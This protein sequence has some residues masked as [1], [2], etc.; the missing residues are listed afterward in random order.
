MGETIT[1]QQ[2]LAVGGLLTLGLLGLCG[3]FLRRLLSD[4][5][6]TKTK[7][8]ELSTRVDNL[9]LSVEQNFVSFDTFETM[10]VEFRANFTNIFQSQAKVGEILARLDE[11][12]KWEERL[13]TILD[14]VAPPR[15]GK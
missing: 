13:A 5:D 9:K 14:R 10:R 2:V 11:R 4:H 1:A 12:S 15:R 8:E 6:K 3:F 7:I